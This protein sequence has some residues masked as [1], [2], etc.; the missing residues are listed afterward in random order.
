M[1]NLYQ[2]QHQII[3]LEKQIK[4]CCTS[5]SDLTQIKSDI[6]NLQNQVANFLADDQNANEVFTTQ[7]IG[8]Y[9]VGTSVQTILLGLSAIAHNPVTLTNNE[10]PFSFNS[11]TQTGNIPKV[12][13]LTNNNDG[14]FTFKP[15]DATTPTTFKTIGNLVSDSFTVNS[16]NTVTLSNTIY[17]NMQLFVFR[18]GLFT[19]DYSIV[20][21]NIIFTIPFG[22][23][24]GAIGDETINVEYYTI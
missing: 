13:S 17:S 16:G 21:N 5:S 7:V 15:G 9:P 20:G 12:G 10:A 6:L 8:S 3:C 19:K 24:G 4:E 23:S 22:N 2:M 1:Y 11:L 14:T 18:N